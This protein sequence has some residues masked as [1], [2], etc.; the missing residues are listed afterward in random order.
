MNPALIRAVYSSYKN[1]R[2]I[3]NELNRKLSMAQTRSEWISTYQERS[4]TIKAAFDVNTETSVLINDAVFGTKLDY[5]YAEAFF[6]EDFNMASDSNVDLFFSCTL[7]ETLADYYRSQHDLLRLI[8]IL[9]RLGMNYVATVKMHVEENYIKA[10]DCFKEVI[11]YKDNYSLIPDLSVR[12]LFFQA[13][14]SLCCIVPIIECKDT[15]L[16]SQSLDYLLEV[17]SFYNSPTVQKLDGESEEI[18]ASIDMIKENWLWIEYR[19]DHADPETKAAFIKVVHDVY[20]VNAAKKNILS[21]PVSTVIAYQHALILEGNTSYIDAVN[22]M[23]DYF[24]K[25]K[26]AFDSDPNAE[27]NESDFYFQTKLPIAL[28]KWLDKID[29]LSDMCAMT[30]KRL[31]DE[32]NDYFMLLSKRGIFSHLIYE[33]CCSWCFFAVDYIPTREEKENFII[34]MLINRQP[35]TFFNA[36]L[37]ADLAVLIT[38]ALYLHTPILLNSCENFLKI[39]GMPSTRYDVIEFIRKCALFHDIGLNLVSKIDGIQYRTLSDTELNVL[40]KHPQLGAEIAQGSLA[41][42]RDVILGHHKTYDQTGG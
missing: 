28:I 2:R 9:N 1:Q 24:Y 17:L 30:R 41:I 3:M 33:S 13:Y 27:F 36:Y 40:K 26:S 15:I 10:L 7:L 31:I 19:I 39:H 37:N 32:Q 35:Q 42:Y 25:K 18:R 22:Y 14:Y 4:A 8:P 21:L 20:D 5:D 16:P 23:M 38:E 29:I 11:T 12:K 6:H 34:S